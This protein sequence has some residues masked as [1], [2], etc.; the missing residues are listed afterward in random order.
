M[1]YRNVFRSRKRALVTFASLF[2]GLLIYLTVSSSTQKL[3]YNL[4]YDREMPYDFV[5]EDISWQLGNE[6]KAEKSLDDGILEKVK[7]R[8]SR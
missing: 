4:K 5:M 2:F 7:P 3:D 6:E 1:A 8:R